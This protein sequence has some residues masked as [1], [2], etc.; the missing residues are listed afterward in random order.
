[1]ARADWV[2]ACGERGAAR[3]EVIGRSGSGCVHL[4]HCVLRGRWG[5]WSVGATSWLPPVT[6]HSR[7]AAQRE[8]GRVKKEHRSL[9][10]G[11]QLLLAWSVYQ[12]PLMKAAMKASRSS[13]PTE[14]LGL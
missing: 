12:Q 13:G 1:M 4:H 9:R 5:G 10:S 14:P 3:E 8:R 6:R 2:A 11:F 7:V